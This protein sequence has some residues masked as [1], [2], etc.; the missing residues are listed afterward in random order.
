M[1][2]S[3]DRGE[4]GDRTTNPNS[5]AHATDKHLRTILDN[6]LFRV[7]PSRGAIS[8][9]HS[10][11]GTTTEQQRRIIEEPMAVFDELAASGSVTSTAIAN[12]L[13]SQLLLATTPS[14]T[15][16]KNAMKDSKAGSKVVAWFWASDSAARKMLF[17]VPTSSLLKFMAAEGLQD[18]A[19]V[20]LS[21][22]LKHDVGGSDGQIP[23]ASV[24][25]YFSHLLVDFMA[26]EIQYGN[27]LGS[28]MK[29]YLK[30]YKMYLLLVD[31]SS[32]QSKKPMLLSP[33]ARL[34][35]WTMEHAQGQA[36]EI[37]ASVYEEFTDTISTLSSPGSL[38]SA[39]VP[40][41]HPTHS[42]TGPLLK[43][44]ETHPPEKCRSW[45]DRKRETL[46][47]VSFDAL[48]VLVDRE[49]SRKASRL[50]HYIQ[51]L[52]PNKNSSE[53]TSRRYHASPEEE[54]L[55]DRL[56]IALAW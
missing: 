27:G 52:L 55:L 21:M 12:C 36:K 19:M 1:L 33:G 25:Q 26:A 8:R 23:E 15:G 2:H 7:V 49:E 31:P 5:S 13:K 24:R 17:T 48:R 35:Q 6:P 41:Y 30:A 29:Y 11:P 54:Y 28:A 10:G 51:Q 3:S 22:L 46:L 38:L 9:D 34:S 4:N 50:A 40:L 45:S 43:F 14:G 47:R 42:E 18:T 32:G 37:P 16:V 53:T 20:W 44:V 39:S 56:D